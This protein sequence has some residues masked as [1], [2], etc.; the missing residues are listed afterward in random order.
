M[1]FPVGTPSPSHN[2]TTGLMSFLRGYPI[3]WSQVRTGGVPTMGTPSFSQ[4][5]T[6]AREGYHG[7]PIPSARD[8]VVVVFVDAIKLVAHISWGKVC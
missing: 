6:G 3:A 5:R 7:E 8:G 1:F 2:T 4:V